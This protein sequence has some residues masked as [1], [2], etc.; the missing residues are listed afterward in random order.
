M[1][2]DPCSPGNQQVSSLVTGPYRDYRKVLGAGLPGRRQAF[3]LG[4]PLWPELALVRAGPCACAE[5]A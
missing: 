5:G 2:E 4:T 1:A 3:L